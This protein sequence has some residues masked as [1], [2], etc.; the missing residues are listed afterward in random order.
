MGVNK[1]ERF[2][3]IAAFDHVY[4]LSDF[5][6]NGARK[7]KGRWAEIFGNDHPVVLELA[8]GKGTYTTALARRYPEKNFIGVD[9]KGAR[10]W[11]G[12]KRAKKEKLENVRFLRIYIDHLDEYF[13]PAEVDDIWITFP[14]PYPRMSDRNK[15][16]TSPKFLSIYQNVLAKDGC[17][18]LKT[19]SEELFTYT[20]KVIEQTGC[21]LL[22]KIED[23]YQECPDNELLTIKTDFEKK[24]LKSGRTITYLRFN[25]PEEPIRN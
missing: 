20:Q 16:L 25:L 3:Q 17:I 11:K 7:P 10:I 24:H 8:C 12:A 21:T 13:A 19:D 18:R 22:R 2:K 23:I 9:I 6:H 1:L 14:D 5:Q 4:E 15:R